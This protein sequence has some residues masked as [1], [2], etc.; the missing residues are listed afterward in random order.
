MYSIYK[1]T[2]MVACS[3]Q[4]SAK[5]PFFP[6]RDCFEWSLKAIPDISMMS[7]HILSTQIFI[8]AL[9]EY[10][11]SKSISFIRFRKWHNIVPWMKSKTNFQRE[12]LNKF[13][14]QYIFLKVRYSPVCN[15]VMVLRPGKCQAEF[16]G[17]F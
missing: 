2:E 15:W 13:E 14:F 3:F 17:L 10:F 12:F 5:K 8:L 16:R 11:T 6:K 7:N 9:F 1:V 4:K